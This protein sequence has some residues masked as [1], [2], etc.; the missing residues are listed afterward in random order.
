MVRLRA[1]LNRAFRAA[2]GASGAAVYDLDARQPLFGLRDGLLR[3]PA[4]LEKL[5][6]S[7]ALLRRLG[8]HARLH[9]VVLGTGHLGPGGVWH[10]D[11]YLRGGG[12]PTFGDGAFNRVWNRGAGPTTAQ[13][14]TQ[15]ISD[16]IKRVT[17]RVI[18]D[19][20]LFDDR[21]G[22]PST[23]FAPDVPD[24]GGQLSALT[25]DHGSTLG[26]LSPAAFAARQLAMTLRA[27]GVRANPAPIAARA[28]R[29]ARA[30]ASVSSPPLAQLLALMN[31][32][33]DDL[34]AEM[35]T[36]QLGV[37]FGGR[38][39]TQAG[40]RVI[41]STIGQYGLHPTILD[42]SGLDRADRSSPRE[43]VAL[44]RFVWGTS[45]GRTLSSSLPLVGV[46]GTARRIATAPSVRGRCVAK[47]GTLDQI[48]NLAG[49]CYTRG[50]HVL[51][52][53][54]FIDGPANENAI[55]FLSQMVTAIVSY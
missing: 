33:S 54:L 8:P 44:L 51:A 45:I 31:L 47:T 1:A 34:Y 29:A 53:A 13:L 23:N 30:L 49:Y 22:G 14:A 6:T 5:Y 50:R 9:T 20:T 55:G 39:S 35:L 24:F 36:K 3:A 27:A 12:D 7:V 25:F 48:T 17:G 15:L 42:G 21:A 43:I 32:P 2:G 46:N 41:A 28:P 52:F 40:A 19:A 4:S 26:K 37:R 11:L 38:G 10:G 18:G 16:R